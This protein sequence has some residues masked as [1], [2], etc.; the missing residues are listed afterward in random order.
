MNQKLKHLY[1]PIKIGS[2]TLKNRLISAPSSQ[3]DIENDGTLSLH[4]IAYYARK[5]KGGCALVTVGDGI[6][7][8]SGQDHPKQ[9]YLYT[10]RC[11]PSLV[12]CAEE[13]HKYNCLASYELSH[14]GIVCNPEFING[15]R[16]WGPSE[17]PVSIGFQTDHA[18]QIYARE[19][20]LEMME[21]LADAYAAAAARVK[22]AGFDMVMVH[23]AHGWLI[24]QFFTPAVNKRTDEFGGSIENRCRF[25]IMVLKKVR[26]AVGK[27]FPI[28]FRI[29]G[30]DGI[31]NGLTIEECVEICKVLEPY[32]DAFH[33]SAS[34]HY[35]AMLQDYMQSP[36]YEPHGHL[37]PLAAAVKKAVKKP[38]AAVGG[39]SDLEMMEQAV[40]EG[41]AD[42]IAMGRQLLA[43]PD[44]V[45][46]GAQGREDQV[47]RCL[48]C[49]TCQSGRF[50]RGTARCAINPEMGREY[51]CQ[52]LS[53]PVEK[54][55]Y[56]IAGGGPGGMEAA[57]IAA[58][59]GHKVTLYEKSQKLGGALNFAENVDFKADL[60]HLARA[61]EAELR[62]LPVE[63]KLGTELTP[64]I[65]VAE[66]ADILVCA[67]G[68]D[69]IYPPFPG[70]DRENV[71]MASEV[72]AGTAQLGEKVV[73]VGGG[74]VGCETALHLARQGKD[75]TIVEMAPRVCGDAN[76]RYSRT[77]PK[78]IRKWNVKTAVDTSCSAIESNG[79]RVQSKDGK[80]YLIEADSVVLSVGM[81]S[82]TAQAEALRFCAPEYVAIGNCVRPGIVQNAIRGGYDAATF[83]D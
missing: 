1:Q 50:M 82:R 3:G 76:F 83:L 59:R 9:V 65:A 71:Y 81:R 11:L 4:N 66:N 68:A 73:V 10:D 45:K 54:K 16:P 26:Q 70:V 22:K 57:I 30:D 21:E 64:E 34:V 40:A 17:V 43:D 29:N 20:T 2:V 13:I 72:D 55:K 32:V 77:I 15:E 38:V 62:S 23:A 36:M 19:L 8:P 79:V 46:K 42:I 24:G 6:V 63:I 52:F 33:V 51:E 58:R 35:D 37:L 39:F 61:M 44:I 12:R 48:R 41:S 53:L 69:E 14:G 25:A 18:V 5:A 31:E 56:L 67:V 47:R 75:V 80:E 49:A 74:L 60:Y 78:E 7:H 27:D 28:D